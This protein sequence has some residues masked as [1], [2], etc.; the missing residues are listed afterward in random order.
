[1]GPGNSV[2][3]FLGEVDPQSGDL[4]RE[5]VKA[6]SAVIGEDPPLFQEDCTQGQ[7]IAMAMKV[8]E[9]TRDIITNEADPNIREQICMRYLE[10]LAIFTE[11]EYL[12]GLV[13]TFKGDPDARAHSLVKT[14]ITILTAI[15]RGDFLGAT[16]EA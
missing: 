10:K 9:A 15:A 11:D 3:K 6:L 14:T 7:K 8:A 5:V 13:R 12:Q 2:Q 16:Q 4:E 1:M